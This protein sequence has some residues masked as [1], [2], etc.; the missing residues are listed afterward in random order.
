MELSISDTEIDKMHSGEIYF[1]RKSIGVISSV[2][3]IKNI[4]N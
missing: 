1:L 2:H 3:V 4:V